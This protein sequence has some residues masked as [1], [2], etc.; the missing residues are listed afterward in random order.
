MAENIFA[1]SITAADNDDADTA[2]PWAEGM[3]PGSVNN[4][5]RALMA[6]V[7]RFR[8]DITGAVTTTGSAGSYAFTSR[9]DFTALAT[10]LSITAKASVT[11]TA[12]ATLNVNTLGAKSIRVF[13]NGAEAAVAA[14]QIIS[15]S[16]YQF[17]Y[18]TALNSSAGGW[19]LLNPAPD[20][21][22]APNVGD[23]KP[24]PSNTLPSGNWL[25]ANGEAVSRTTYAT[26]FTLIG[27]TYG[28]GN[29]STTF[30]VPDLCGRA[31]YG[32]DDM[33]GVASKNRITVAGSGIDGDVLGT[34]GGAETHTLTTAQLASHS[35]TGVTGAESAAHNHSGVTDSGGVDHTHTYDDHQQ[36][37]NGTVGGVPNT[38][39]GEAS[40]T[41]SGASAFL[42][43]HSFTTGIENVPHTHAFTS[44]ASG[45]GS[46]H[47]NMPPALILNYVIRH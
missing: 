25:W 20:P 1:W 17:V 45:S 34:A 28:A 10:N 39:Q 11:N 26:L 21:L 37:Y 15:G 12:G 4:S 24:W 33:G 22:Q 35:H 9:S 5:A 44:D 43:A 41:T 2:V 18:D 31:P 8:D 47:N 23:I 27:T 6:A 40:G 14:G 13:V 30:N 3:V 46:A 38:L 16:R 36:T 42:H 32:S 19:L 7:A 29:G